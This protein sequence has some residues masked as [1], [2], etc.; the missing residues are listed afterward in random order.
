MYWEE[1]YEE[2]SKKLFEHFDVIKKSSEIFIETEENLR[3]IMMETH[4]K[5]WLKESFWQCELV[6]SSF[7]MRECIEKIKSHLLEFN[8]YL[9]SIEKS[10]PYEEEE[11][12]KE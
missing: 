4:H 5:N 8:Q 10:Y 7:K 11:D 6:Q 9:Y 12:K 3:Q 1:S 2:L